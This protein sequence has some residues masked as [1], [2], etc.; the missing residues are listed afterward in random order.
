LIFFLLPILNEAE[1]P[2]QFQ[3][4]PLKLLALGG[5]DGRFNCALILCDN[6]YWPHSKTAR[7]WARMRQ[8]LDSVDWK[9]LSHYAV[10]DG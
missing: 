9:H 8:D 4:F 1:I 7:R 3:E 2:A 5:M 10:V 6:M